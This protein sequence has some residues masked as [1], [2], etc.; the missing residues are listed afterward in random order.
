MASNL[1]MKLWR[2]KLSHIIIK[3]YNLY[4]LFDNRE[5][6]LRA[7]KMMQCSVA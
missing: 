4:N 7:L 2:H 3:G 1:H 5:V 6:V